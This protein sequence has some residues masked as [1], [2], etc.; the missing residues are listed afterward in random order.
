MADLEY[1]CCGPIVVWRSHTEAGLRFLSTHGE[2][3]RVGCTLIRPQ[4]NSSLLK[5]AQEEGLTVQ[6]L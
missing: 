2:P 4:N 5:E 6:E 3:D 1:E